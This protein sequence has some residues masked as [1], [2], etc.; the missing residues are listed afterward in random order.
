MARGILLADIAVLTDFLCRQDA[1]SCHAG[2]IQQV[3]I[4]EAVDYKLQNPKP[5]AAVGGCTAI[6]RI[7][8]PGPF[9]LCMQND[10]P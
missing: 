1:G 2:L 7:L 6:T 4:E 9:D 10:S 3:W 8:K 5:H